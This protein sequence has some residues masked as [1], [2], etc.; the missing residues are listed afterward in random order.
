MARAGVGKIIPD[1]VA[2]KKAAPAPAP[3]PAPKPSP[4]PAPRLTPNQADRAAAK[5]APKPSPA[6]APVKQTAQFTK[7][8][9]EAKERAA[10]QPV[11]AKQLIAAGEYSGEAHRFANM[12]ANAAK[13]PT[14]KTPIKTTPKPI[15]TKKPTVKPPNKTTGH[16][17]PAPPIT[18]TPPPI[19]N[20]PAPTV[21][22]DIF[23]YPDSGYASQDPVITPPPVK[24][25]PIDTVIFVD[26]TFSKELITDL[27]FEDVGGQ[28]LLTIARNDTVNGQLVAYQP[29][30]NL[31]ILQ[32]IYNPTT[33]LRLQETSDKFFSNF[34][35]NL[36]D[37]IPKVGSG[38]DG[39]NYYLDL[40]SGEGVIE[41][42]NLRSDEQIEVQIAGAG[43]IEDVGI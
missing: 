22:N 10:A 32:E 16:V 1:R 34:T 5:P 17:K 4:A 11:T 27:L 14:V 38:T 2:P 39:A 37:K 31:D 28:E 18:L 33:L 15:V 12:A 19:I 42:I 20:E 40:A 29:F 9:I 41:F 13:K 35:I 21:I 7:A 6:P 43:I 24:S 26:E 8:Q 3:K 23:P 25:A 36:R 30:K